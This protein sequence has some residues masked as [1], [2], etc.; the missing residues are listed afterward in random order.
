[1]I[2]IASKNSSKRGFV[3]NDNFREPLI[4]VTY[5][6][7]QKTHDENSVP[8]NIATKDR[9]LKRR[10]LKKDAENESSI[11]SEVRQVNDNPDDDDDGIDDEEE[12]EGDEETKNHGV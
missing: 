11:T 2:K 4:T 5:E 12:E 3:I 10:K 9:K 8:S 6:G 7:I 1:L